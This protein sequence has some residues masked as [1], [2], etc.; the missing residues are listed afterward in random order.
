M[1]CYHR[2]EELPPHAPG[3]TNF[4]PPAHFAAHLAA[5]ARWGFHGVTVNDVLEWKAGR[6]ALPPRPIAITFD[7]AYE[8]VATTALPLMTAYRWPATVYAISGYLGARN[9][10]DQGAAPARHLDAAALRTLLADGHDVGSHTRHHKRVRGLAGAHLHEELAS[11][12]D[13]L[14]QQLGAACTSFAF[15]YGSHDRTVLDATQDAGYHGACTLKRWANGRRTNAFRLGRLS[16]G[17]PV[18]AWLLLAKV[19]KL[20]LTPAAN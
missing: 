16:V 11:S 1:L 4:V 17:G 12:K 9:T 14:E 7:D 6:K 3:D 8:S 5:L 18:P 10:W 13:D 15:P 2:I 19:G 20:M